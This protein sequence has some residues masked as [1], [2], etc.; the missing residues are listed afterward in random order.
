MQ[1]ELKIPVCCCHTQGAALAD[2]LKRLRG[3]ATER[4]H[5]QAQLGLLQAPALPR[6]SRLHDSFL[7]A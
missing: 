6:P 5:M 3:A 2:E 1:A 4:D 7:A